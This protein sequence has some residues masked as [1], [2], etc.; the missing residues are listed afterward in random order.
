MRTLGGDGN[1]AEEEK[2]RPARISKMAQQFKS[3][4]GSAASSK[5]LSSVFGSSVG[6][7]VQVD[8]A[9]AGT[10]AAMSASVTKSEE[11]TMDKAVKE[12]VEMA[13]EQIDTE[14]LQHAKQ[15]LFSKSS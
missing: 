13:S 11:S 5:P 3:I 2:N 7:G 9:V 14:M 15:Q 12:V 6:R 1:V 10:L 8:S 4:D